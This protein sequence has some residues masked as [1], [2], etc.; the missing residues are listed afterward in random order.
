[1]ALMVREK[2]KLH[3]GLAA[4]KGHNIKPVRPVMFINVYTESSLYGAT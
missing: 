4:N 2:A 3:K 1:M